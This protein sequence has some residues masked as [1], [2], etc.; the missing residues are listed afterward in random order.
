M[1][2]SQTTL[3]RESFALVQP[4]A[5]AAAALFY[6][7]LF[8]ADPSVRG[9][10]RGDLGEQGRRLFHMIGNGVALLDRPAHLLPVLR[11]L[12]ALHTAYGVEEHHYDTVGAVLLHTL[13]QGLGER[14][15]PEV[16]DAW[17]AFYLLVATTMREGARDALAA[18]A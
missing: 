5:D 10:F 13:S 2:P 3:V 18:A 8:E 1:T 17:R 4:I 9:L 15:S 7:N 6:A 16:Q 12:G 14:F 11:S